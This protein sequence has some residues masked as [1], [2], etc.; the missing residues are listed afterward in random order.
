MNAKKVEKIAILVATHSAVGIFV[1]YYP[2]SY[3]YWLHMAF[4]GFVVATLASI[5]E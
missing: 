3:W 2:E 4:A 1:S 5:A